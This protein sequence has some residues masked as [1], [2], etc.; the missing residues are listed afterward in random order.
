MLE[1]LEGTFPSRSDD[2][3]RVPVPS[4]LMPT[5]RNLAGAT[6]DED[7]RIVISIGQSQCVA[8]YP[9]LVFDSLLQRLEELKAENSKYARAKEI[10]KKYMVRNTLDKQHRFKIQN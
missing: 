2:R 9:E 6:G 5:F 10:L 4:T 8:V 1:E 7:V 3:N